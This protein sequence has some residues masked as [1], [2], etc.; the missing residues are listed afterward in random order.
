ME[1]KHSCHIFD[2]SGYV[3]LTICIYFQDKMS[4]AGDETEFDGAILLRLYLNEEV[5]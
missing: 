4:R 1:Y 3:Q 5:G 2:L